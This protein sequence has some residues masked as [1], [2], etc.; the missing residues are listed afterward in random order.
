MNKKLEAKLVKEFP[1]LYRDYGGPM[2]KTS[3]HFGFQCDD[4]WFNLIHALS[5]RIRVVSPNARALQVKEKF[6]R[7]AFY[8][9]GLGGAKMRDMAR[10][11]IHRTEE[12]SAFTC[13]QCGKPGKKTVNDMGWIKTLCAKCKALRKRKDRDIV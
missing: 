6:G 9:K 5:G 10:E 8:V 3:L 1:K 4:G 11:L 12:A 13:E 7:L 2:K